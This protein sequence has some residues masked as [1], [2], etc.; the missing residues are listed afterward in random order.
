MDE[1]DVFALLEGWLV[2]FKAYFCE[3]FERGADEIVIIGVCCIFLFEKGA[4]I[5]CASLLDTPQSD[6]GV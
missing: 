1:I 2:I 3:R 4:H 6:V 5:T